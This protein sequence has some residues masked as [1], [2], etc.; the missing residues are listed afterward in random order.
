MAMTHTS[1]HGG[2]LDNDKNCG[3]FCAAR[4]P[5]S[6]RGV[7]MEWRHL[8]SF[9]SDS[10]SYLL[11]M[12]P[13]LT[14][15]L[16]NTVLLIFLRAWNCFYLFS[17]ENFAAHANSAR[18]LR[19]TLQPPHQDHATLDTFTLV[20]LCVV[21]VMLAEPTV[22]DSNFILI[23]NFEHFFDFPNSQLSSTSKKIFRWNPRHQQVLFTHERQSFKFNAE[24]F[25][26]NFAI[27]SLALFF[28]FYV[29]FQLNLICRCQLR[30]SDSG[31]SNYGDDDGSI[32]EA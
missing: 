18:A 24:S 22:N 5:R 23:R 17:V 2:E 11:W 14:T 19:S 6:R 30:W 4:V 26:L 32:S 13:P 21:M 28:S 10:R 31:W 27:F 12:M 8:T 1:T 29:S 25:Y 9:A 16:T 3:T 20:I 7:G 15:P